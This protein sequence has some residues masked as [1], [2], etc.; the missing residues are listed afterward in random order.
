MFMKLLI[1]IMRVYLWIFLVGEI[2]LMMLM[3]SSAIGTIQIELPLFNC[4]FHEQ[5]MSNSMM[6]LIQSITHT[7]LVLILFT[8]L[9]SWKESEDLAKHLNKVSMCAF[10]A[11]IVYAG[12]YY[13]ASYLLIGYGRPTLQFLIY[14]SYAIM[15]W[16]ISGYLNPQLTESSN[17]MKDWIK[18][19]V[20]TED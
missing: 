15:G 10:F 5:N 11:S 9:L 20:T 19:F 3:I 16:T 1:R 4:F 14:F 13:F 7:S 6:F 2:S 17:I 12:V 18:N 8:K